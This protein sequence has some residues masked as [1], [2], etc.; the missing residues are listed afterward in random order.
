MAVEVPVK[1]PGASVLREEVT[2]TR[3]VPGLWN[4]CDDVALMLI[5]EL[6]LPSPHSY[7]T[8]MLF[9]LR[10]ED[11]LYGALFEIL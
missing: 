8:R 10:E 3:C 1:T 11:P 7:L 2:N 6:G 4:T 9:R 5:I